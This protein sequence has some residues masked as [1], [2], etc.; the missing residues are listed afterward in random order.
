MLARDEGGGNVSGLCQRF[1]ISTKTAY[2][3][4]ERFEEQG[5]A[6]LDAAL[7]CPLRAHHRLRNRLVVAQA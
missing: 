3:W 2:K 6:G 4:L 5:P 7:I 1:G